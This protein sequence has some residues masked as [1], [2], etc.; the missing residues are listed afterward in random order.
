M[1]VTTHFRSRGAHLPFRLA[2]LLVSRPLRHFVISG[3]FVGRV[4]EVE[5][6]GRCVSCSTG[7]WGSRCSR[8][9]LV[10]CSWCCL[11]KI[12]L[13][14]LKCNRWHYWSCTAVAAKNVGFGKAVTTLRRMVCI[15]GWW[16]GVNAEVV[17]S[18][19]SGCWV[20]MGLLFQSSSNH[21]FRC[22]QISNATPDFNKDFLPVEIFGRLQYFRK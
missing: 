5:G 7:L 15:Y 12:S 2:T 20:L 19:F 17:C 10:L 22:I 14:V 16:A 8:K 18:T 6:K 3:S 13:V 1:T 9:Y 11:F 4:A 21:F